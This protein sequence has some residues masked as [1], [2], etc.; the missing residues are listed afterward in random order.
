MPRVWLSI[1][2]NVDRERNIRSAVKA[3]RQTWGELMISRIYES[4]AVGCKGDRFFNLVVGFE[5]DDPIGELNACLRAIEDAHGRKRVPDK[6]APR[7]LDID[8]LTYGD[9][10]VRDGSLELPREEITRYAFIL[11]PLAELAGD[12]LHP[13][14][15]RTYGAL[16][17]AFNKAGQAL[18]PAAFQLD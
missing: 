10:V 1:G 16:W 4:E 2:S 15:G 5:T 13:T 8:L 18:W 17:D 3:L 14:A 11:K 9:A 6:F 12:Q 7:T